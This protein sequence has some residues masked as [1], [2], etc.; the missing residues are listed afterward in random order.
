MKRVRSWLPLGSASPSRASRGLGAYDRRNQQIVQFPCETNTDHSHKKLPALSDVHAG[1]RIKYTRGIFSSQSDDLVAE[2]V[3]RKSSSRVSFEARL[4]E[5]VSLLEEIPSM[6]ELNAW[7]LGECAIPILGAE[8]IINKGRRKEG[9]TTK[10]GSSELVVFAG[11]EI[12]D[13]RIESRHVV[14][15]RESRVGGHKVVFKSSS[16]GRARVDSD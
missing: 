8:A 5:V 1:V 12:K 9:S 11:D 2:H 3:E 15:S 7:Q 10:C 16:M 13:G 4:K 6:E 14:D